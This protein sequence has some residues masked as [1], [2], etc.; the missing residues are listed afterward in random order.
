MEFPVCVLYDIVVDI[1][2]AVGRGEAHS[3]ISQFHAVE[4]ENIILR[5]SSH[6]IKMI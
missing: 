1:A 2:A 6:S 3:F 5:S 4:N